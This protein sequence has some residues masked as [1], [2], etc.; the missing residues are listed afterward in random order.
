MYADYS[1]IMS[2]IL[3]NSIEFKQ[4]LYVED[5]IHN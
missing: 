1:L 3:I 5:E 4:I 2:I